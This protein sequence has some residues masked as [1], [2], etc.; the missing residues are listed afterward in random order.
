MSRQA[1]QT[2]EELEGSG[3]SLVGSYSGV[4]WKKWLPEACPFVSGFVL[5]QYARAASSSDGAGGVVVCAR[6]LFTSKCNTA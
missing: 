4:G 5:D 6:M 2:H 3:R 1:G